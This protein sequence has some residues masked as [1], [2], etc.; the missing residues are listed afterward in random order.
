MLSGSE[1]YIH[2]YTHTPH[3]IP[4]QVLCVNGTEFMYTH[5]NIT[6]SDNLK[7]EDIFQMHTTHMS[8]FS[9]ILFK[10][11]TWDANKKNN[12]STSC[13][14]L[15]KIALLLSPCRPFGPPECYR[16]CR[17]ASFQSK[18]HSLFNITSTVTNATLNT[19]TEHYLYNLGCRVQWTFSGTVLALCE[20]VPRQSYAEVGQSHDSCE[21]TEQIQP[22]YTKWHSH[23]VALNRC[24]VMRMQS[25]HGEDIRCSQDL[26]EELWFWWV[27]L[28][29]LGGVV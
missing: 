6:V 23:T 18:W 2:P 25:P 28:C 24:P 22:R 26:P 4:F 5:T 3:I 15:Y 12:S 11:P 1:S 29:R 16:G 9:W 17:T 13:H 10:I 20:M 14:F 27:S 7:L 19:N 21:P 8:N